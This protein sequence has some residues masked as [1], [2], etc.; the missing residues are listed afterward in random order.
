M[1]SLRNLLEEATAI[2]EKDA[3]Q[4]I[5]SKVAKKLGLTYKGF[6]RWADPQSNKIVAKTIDGKLV[7]VAPE[8]PNAQPAY[9]KG[10]EYDTGRNMTQ[11]AKK[12][13]APS[14]RP[15]TD[16]QANNGTY[17]KTNKKLIQTLQKNKDRI[18][19]DDAMLAKAT[20]MIKKMNVTQGVHPN[21]V[22]YLDIIAQETG[23]EGL[24]R[25]DQL[26]ADTYNTKKKA[27]EVEVAQ[28]DRRA[29]RNNPDEY[30]TSMIEVDSLEDLW[31][32]TKWTNTPHGDS[33][34]YTPEPQEPDYDENDY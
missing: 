17:L 3:E 13:D 27:F 33:W 11:L 1:I 14:G 16:K 24:I 15:F 5:A 26:I 31:N 32:N 21:D 28:L 8:E 4:L 6:G 34:E 10:G 18:D 19:N 29:S 2:F 25:A 20:G 9:G 23:V 30:S 12:V 22:E 7:K